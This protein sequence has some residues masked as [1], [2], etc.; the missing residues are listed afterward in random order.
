MSAWLRRVGLAS[1][2]ALVAG[3]CGGGDDSAEPEAAA[4]T[5]VPTTA[6]TSV[7]TAVPT[8]TDPPAASDAPAVSESPEAS[9]SDAEPSDESPGE[10]V[11]GESCFA[12][13]ADDSNFG[14]SIDCTEPHDLQYAGSIASPVAVLPDD[15]Q[16]ATDLLNRAC[17]PLVEEV[18]GRTLTIPG[19]IVAFS[20]PDAELGEPVPGDVE[21]YAGGSG[22]DLLVAQ[23]ADVGAEAAYGDGRII[24]DLEPG[25]CFV[26]L[27]DSFDI[28]VESG[29]EAEGAL[30][31]V[32][33][34]VADPGPYPGEDALRALRSERCAEVLAA[35]PSLS[36][37]AESISGT[38]PDRKS[39]VVQDMRVVTC[40]AEPAG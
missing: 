9:A 40:D 16:E 24:A 36:G 18:A 26:F 6:A 20:A 14:E 28:G 10:L 29:C 39:W 12:A 32:G 11:V 25:T 17:V 33:S 31:F 35:A 34:F 5:V 13:P 3:A 30:V 7:S 1:A 2:V 21:C 19:V 38:I 23:M 27:G 22:S 15:I 8:A 4:T 37:I